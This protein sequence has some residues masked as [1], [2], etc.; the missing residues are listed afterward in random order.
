[1]APS[2]AAQWFGAVATLLAVIVA[3]SK[4]SIREWW[5]KPKLIATCENSPPCNVRTPLFVNDPTTG[6][7]LWTG[8]SYWVR[9][10][11]ENKGRTRAEKIQV[12]LSKLYYRPAVVDGDYSEVLNHH[13]PIN[14]RWTH[15]HVPIQDGISPDMSALGDIIALCDPGNPHWP[16]PANIPPNTTVGRLQLEVDLPPEFHSLRPGSWKLTLRIGAANAK[17]IDQTLLFSHTGEWR[18]TDD[19]MRRECLRV[20]LT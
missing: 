8:D 18:Q 10:K 7:L 12:S 4:D 9:V 19:D 14:L 16:K 2:S 17:P 6:N 15:V 5:R 1:M 3:L 13:L 20:S 11:V